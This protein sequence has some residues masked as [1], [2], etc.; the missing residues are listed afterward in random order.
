MSQH[1]RPSRLAAATLALALSTGAAGAHY[2]MIIPTTPMLGQKDGRS[3]GLTL[4]FSHPFELDGMVLEMPEAFSVTHEG[5]TTDLTGDLVEATVMGQPGYTLDY[6]IARPG[7]YVFAMTPQPY[8]EPADDAFITHY[9]KT[10]VSAFGEDEGWDIELGLK[11]EIVPISKPFGLWAGNVFQGTVLFDGAPSPFA[12]VEV[13]FYNE[14]G[15]AT[16]PSELMVTQTIKADE[17]GI[18][19]Y[20]TPAAGWWGFAALTTAEE[21]MMFEGEEKDHE[22][23]AVIW[24]RFEEWG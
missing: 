18:F 4:S 23:G 15:T 9:T 6:P 22:L 21:P 10:Y 24:V 1:P 2:G 16:V 8:W 13:E 3:V 11:T 12:E 5:E 7:T 14:E 19:T 17:E 20:A